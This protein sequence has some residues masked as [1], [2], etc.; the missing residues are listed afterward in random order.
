MTVQA[1]SHFD[2]IYG[3]KYADALR[4]MI[5]GWVIMY[6][7]HE[8]HLLEQASHWLGLSTRRTESY[9]PNTGHRGQSSVFGQEIEWQEFL[10]QDLTEA[11]LLTR[12]APGKK[13]LIPDF[14]DFI[15][16]YRQAVNKRIQHM[17]ATQR[18]G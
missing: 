17:S 12:G 4:D 11:R 13:V 3:P 7:S 1:S 6:G 5:P 2:V 14:D 9:E 8:C 15:D 16:I 10:P 18:S